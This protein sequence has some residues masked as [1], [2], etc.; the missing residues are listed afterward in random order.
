MINFVILYPGYMER[1]ELL[2]K[3]D[4]Q[5]QKRRLD[6]LILKGSALPIGDKD[7]VENIEEDRAK[8]IVANVIT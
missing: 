8:E 5:E 6:C 2:A 7:A 3:Q 1:N 4:A